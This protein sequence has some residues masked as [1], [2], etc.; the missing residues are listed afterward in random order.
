MSGSWQEIRPEPQNSPHLGL[1]CLLA[2]GGVSQLPLGALC[3]LPRLL[4]QAPQ[5]SHQALCFV[6]R[7]GNLCS[8]VRQQN[9]PEDG[10]A[11]ECQDQAASTPGAGEPLMKAQAAT[12]IAQAAKRGHNFFPPFRDHPA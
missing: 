9:K 1:S 8:R 7:T 10:A 5:L 6:A 2:L 4:K 3:L 11:C 12:A